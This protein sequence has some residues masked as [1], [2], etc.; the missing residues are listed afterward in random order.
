[1]IHSPTLFSS[2]KPSEPS[3]LQAKAPFIGQVQ[4]FAECKRRPRER[5]TSEHGSLRPLLRRNP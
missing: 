5:K 4:A 2:L 3:V 1:M